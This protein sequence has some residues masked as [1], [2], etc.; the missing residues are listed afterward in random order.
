MSSIKEQIIQAIVSKLSDIRT[1]K[2]YSTNMGANVGTVDAQ[3]D[4]DD[5]PAIM[6]WIDPTETQNEHGNTVH[7]MPVRFEGFTVF[8]TSNAS[9]IANQM[10]ADIIECIAGS[11]WT[12]PFTSG[13]TYEPSAGDTLTG[14]TSTA[15]AYIETVTLSSGAWAD[16]DAAGTFT[17][18]RKVGSFSAENFNIGANL[19]VA[20]TTGVVTYSDAIS[21]TTGGLAEEIQYQGG[22]VTVWPEAGDLI[23]GC[24]HTFNIKFKHIIG[25]PYH[26]R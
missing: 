9:T 7:P 5:A 22:G 8:G 16:G 12:I 15:T 13:G 4:P 17:I 24:Q 25:D 26:Q 3:I 2:G 18:R 1:T 11:S 21:T 19:N 6:V 14:A 20:S 10:E 23:V